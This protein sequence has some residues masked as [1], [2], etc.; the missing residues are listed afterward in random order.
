MMNILKIAKS[1]NLP[2]WWICAGFVRSKIW[3]TLHNFNERTPIPD[4]DV[5]YFDPTNIDELK[6]KKLEEMLKTLMTNIPWSVKNEARMHIKSNMPPYSSS[7][8]AISK[9]PETATALGVKLDEKD[10]VILIAPCGIGDVVNLEVKPTPYFTKTKERVEIYEVR[11]SKKNW[12]S[13]WKRLKVYH[14]DISY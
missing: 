9:F 1:L 4:I 11:I 10:N 8:D 3:D 5:I 7:V 2:D 13:I 12:K 14:I 6:E